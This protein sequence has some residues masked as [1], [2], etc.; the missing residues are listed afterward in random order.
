MWV[1]AALK[2]NDGTTCW[3]LRVDAAGSLRCCNVVSE[4]SSFDPDN[5]RVETKHPL[6][7]VLLVHAAS[8]DVNREGPSCRSHRLG[9]VG[10]LHR[11]HPVR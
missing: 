4:R 9:V 10:V 3:L 1:M 11:W 8:H 6:V 5:M 7:V 2:D